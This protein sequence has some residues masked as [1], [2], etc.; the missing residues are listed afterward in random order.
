MNVSIIG[1]GFVG[2]ALELGINDNVEKLLIDPIY[3]NNI[4][5]INNF[6][7]NIIFICVP[8]PM[9]DNGDQDWK[10]L[11]NVLMELKN[12]GMESNIV[13]KSTVLPSGIQNI[14]NSFPEIVYNPEFLTEKNSVNDFIN[15][16][17]IILGG[18]E[19]NTNK[20]SLFYKNH[21]KC[22]TN[23]YIFTDLISASL[24]KYAINCFLASKVIF[25][26]EL[27]QLFVNSDTNEKWENFLDIVSSDSRIGNSHMQVPGPDGRYGFG[28]A[29][30][31]KDAEAFYKYSVLKKS[32]LNL[33]K[34]VIDLNKDIR[35]SYNNL[36]KRE[37]D[38]NIN[39]SSKD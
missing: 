39:F 29:C 27:N 37:I 25:F 14:E 28:G 38:Q 19:D 34:K 22:I 18:M 10:I 35:N 24:I 3:N 23:N 16:D 4:S 11:N 6:N 20:I 1:H 21:T 8:T 31:P 7:P 17:Q 12:N 26:N 36:T 9:K 13:L 5:D 33:L 30:F 15:T 32:P 2:K